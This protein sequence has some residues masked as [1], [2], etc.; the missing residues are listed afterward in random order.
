ML[1]HLKALAEASERLGRCT[2]EEAG[3]LRDLG[4]ELGLRLVNAETGEITD[5]GRLLA[6]YAERAL[7]AAAGFFVASENVSA[8]GWT[9]LDSGR[10]SRGPLQRSGRPQLHVVPGESAWSAPSNCRL[11]PEL[12]AAPHP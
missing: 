10:G 4:I 1:Q 2:H 7:A 5:T 12:R 9:P 8:E 11:G 3:L 6:P